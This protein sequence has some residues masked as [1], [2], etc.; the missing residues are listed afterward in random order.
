MDGGASSRG[1]SLPDN[2]PQ[3]SSLPT[4]SEQTPSKVNLQNPPES[5]Q[6]MTEKPLKNPPSRTED[7]STKSV[8]QEPI[9]DK[10]CLVTNPAPRKPVSRPIRPFQPNPKPPTVVAAVSPMPSV[11][12]SSMEES[13]NTELKTSYPDTENTE[14][15]GTRNIDGNS[16]VNE[17]ESTDL[18]QVIPN[19][20]SSPERDS[21]ETKLKQIVAPTKPVVGNCLEKTYYKSESITRPAKR[22]EAPP[23]SVKHLTCESSDVDE[24]GPGSGG[25]GSGRESEE[26]VTVRKEDIEWDDDT[27]SVGTSVDSGFGE[28][29]ISSLLLHNKFTSPVHFGHNRYVI[30]TD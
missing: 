19:E 30:F 7:P 3:Y 28:C 18:K 16:A 13:D 2:G 24:D 22:V 29:V 20:S 5:P 10:R 15:K 26:F 11:S 25:P 17:E 12:K 9:L 4:A 21:Q 14:V 23:V 1:E 8:D 27:Q 6:L